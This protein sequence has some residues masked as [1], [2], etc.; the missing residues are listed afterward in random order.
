M[1]LRVLAHLLAEVGIG[2]QV[3]EVFGNLVV[4]SGHAEISTLSVYNL[5]GDT[6]GSGCDDRDTGVE[7]F[8]NLDLKTFASGELECDVG[9]IQQSVQDCK[10]WR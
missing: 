8:G 10:M 1:C 4:V 7:G 6:T 9:V 5:E 3:V 2:E